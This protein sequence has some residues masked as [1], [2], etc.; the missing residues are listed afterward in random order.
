[1]EGGIL[2]MVLQ[3]LKPKL[4]VCV[5]WHATPDPEGSPGAPVY[6]SYPKRE[7]TQVRVLAIP[8]IEQKDARWMGHSFIARGSAAP[9]DDCYK[10][11]RIQILR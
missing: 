7:T 10:A 1:L 8:P 6:R 11:P 4:V 5:F 9:V 2:R 3:G